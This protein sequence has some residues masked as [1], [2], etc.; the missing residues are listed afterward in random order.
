MDKTKQNSCMTAGKIFIVATPIGNLS[1]IT[2]R[3]INTLKNVDMILAEDTRVS[4]RL[5]DHY[6]ISTNLRHWDDYTKAYETERYLDMICLEGKNIALISDAGMPLISDPGHQLI[7][8][9]IAKGV[10]V[11]VIPGPSA[12]ISALSASGLIT[13]PFTFIGFFPHEQ[14]AKRDIIKYYAAYNHTVIAFESPKRLL[15]TIEIFNQVL[16][17]AKVVVAREMTKKFEEFLRGF[18]SEIIEVIKGR[19]EVKGEI[20]LLFHPEFV[21]DEIS[22]EK[23][24]TIALDLLKSGE[25]LSEIAK[26]LA[27]EYKVSKKRV[28]DILLKAREGK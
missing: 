18:P 13:V 5:L 25:L 1:D 24:E 17:S 16:P 3:A 10:K 19:Q 9:A 2:L 14:K 7:K 23:L 8:E 12:V 21:Q 6:E 11:E 28:Y 4:S 15:A 20:V 27:A 22:D 26:K